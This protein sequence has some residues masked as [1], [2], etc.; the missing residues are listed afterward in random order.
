VLYDSRVD[1][2]GH[3]FNGYLKRGLVM[4]M[5]DRID[6]SSLEAVA[7]FYGDPA[8]TGVM[9]NLDASYG[10]DEAEMFE[11]LNHAIAE[12]IAARH[13]AAEAAPLR[14]LGRGLAAAAPLKT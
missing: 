9:R 14:P 11:R 2:C 1:H 8:W 5:P 4:A 13:R 6:A 12:T 7:R 10:R 3:D